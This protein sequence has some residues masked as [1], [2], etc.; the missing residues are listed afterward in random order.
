MSSFISPLFENSGKLNF[1]LPPA[2]AGGKKSVSSFISPL[3]ENSDKLNFDL[4][5]ALA[6][7]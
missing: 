2:L 3:F 4:P 7:G 5:P 6:G 1:D